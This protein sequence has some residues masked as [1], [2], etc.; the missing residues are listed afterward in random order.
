M[1]RC[2][3]DLAILEVLSA[4]RTECPIRLQPLREASDLLK[5][6]LE[7]NARAGAAL[8][9]CNERAQASLA[10]VRFS[11]QIEISWVRADGIEHRIDF[12]ITHRGVVLLIRSLEPPE[13]GIFLA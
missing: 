2:V 12:Q 9:R 1:P 6:V 3:A 10:Q 7:R 4:N 11:Q 13:R 8:Q 5:R